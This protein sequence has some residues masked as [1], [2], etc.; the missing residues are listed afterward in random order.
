MP[1]G[2]TFTDY[3]CYKTDRFV[4][5]SGLLH[6]SSGKTSKSMQFPNVIPEGYRALGNTVDFAAFNNGTDDT[7]HG[8]V[9]GAGINFYRSQ[10]VSMTDIRFSVNY[11]V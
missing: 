6:A 7:M 1:S 5:I 10:T 9:N 2:W 11:P 3:G 8:V 4:Y